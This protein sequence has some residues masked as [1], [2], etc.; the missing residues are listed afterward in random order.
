[1]FFMAAMTDDEIAEQALHEEDYWSVCAFVHSKASTVEQYN[2]IMFNVR[3]R[4]LDR[5]KR[6]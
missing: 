5:N 4:W 1:M 2:S 6:N 3:Q